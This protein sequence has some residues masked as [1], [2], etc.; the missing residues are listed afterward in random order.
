MSET[1]QQSVNKLLQELHE[2]A[3]LRRK[4]YEKWFR[5]T[6]GKF[7]PYRIDEVESTLDSPY[8][9]YLD[10]AL[11][12]LESARAYSAALFEIPLYEKHSDGTFSRYEPN[13]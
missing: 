7:P 12:A 2:N 11:A 6:Y 3:E 5:E 10:D 13:K 1:H 4:R 9:R 8:R